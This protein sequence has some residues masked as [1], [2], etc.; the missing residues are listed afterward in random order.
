MPNRLI[1][2]LL[3]SLAVGLGFLAQP[4]AAQ[5]TQRIAATVNN[6]IISTYDVEQRINLV[7][8]SAG[9]DRDPD[10][11]AR[12]RQQV[13]RQLVDEA[14]KLQEAQHWE[15]SVSQEE[16]N[17]AIQDIAGRNDM[18]GEQLFEFLRESGVNPATLLAQVRTDLAWNKVVAGLLRQQ[19]SVSDEEIDF[20]LDRIRGSIN[21][22]QYQ[23]SEI[24]LPV[25]NPQQDEQV[26]QNAERLI[27]QIRQG[28]PFPAVARQF[29]Q[30][31]SA[32]RGGDLGWVQDGQL[33]DEIN[34]ALR[35]LTP[36]QFSL[37]VRS[38]GGYYVIALR[39]RRITGASDPSQITLDLRQI[40]V[41]VDVTRGEQ[42]IRQAGETAYRVSE[43][44]TSCDQVRELALNSPILVG[45][46]IGTR[47]M[48]DL[49]EQF[50]SALR[51]VPEGQATAPI[52]SRVGFHV[53]FVCHREGDNQALPSREEI[54]DQ[55][56]EQQL[57]SVARRHLRDLRRDALIEY[58]EGFDG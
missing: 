32:A 36:G 50:V 31:A 47:R 58:R 3:V 52:P 11:I 56:F 16:L 12:V 33:P 2:P 30:N 20:V 46:D 39:D 44:L 4:V 13:I 51:G 49:N 55:L 43:T 1:R 27:M 19:V 18:T 10:T 57:S 21:Q 40:V 7:I 45:G 14:L 8:F 23:V 17:Q 34:E 28:A 24:F 37:P 9:V 38:S 15:V 35:R 53:L 25:D 54:E 22:P 41:P 48:T 26:R 42:H 29:S 6:A 5:D